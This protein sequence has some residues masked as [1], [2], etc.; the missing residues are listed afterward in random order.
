MNSLLSTVFQY[1]RSIT[2][3][4]KPLEISLDEFFEVVATGFLGQLNIRERI[5]RIR[6]SSSKKEVSKL[7]KQLPSFL[8]SATTKASTKSTDLVEHTGVFQVDLDRQDNPI[9]LKDFSS[10]EWIKQSLMEDEHMALVADSPSGTGIKILIH[11]PHAT[12]DNHSTIY[13]QIL[14]YLIEKYNLVGD[15]SCRN[16]N[17]M[18]FITWDPFVHIDESP[19]PFEGFKAQKSSEMVSLDDEVGGIDDPK[20]RSAVEL[21]EKRTFDI[22]KGYGNWLRLGFFF[23]S[24]GEKGRSYFHRISRFNPTYDPKITDKQFDACMHSNKGQIG[25]GSLFYLMK[26]NG[27]DTSLFTK[28]DAS[29]KNYSEGNVYEYLSETPTFPERVYELLPP[30]INGLLGMIDSPRA[31]DVSLLSVLTIFSVLM[32]RIQ[33]RYDSRDFFSNLFTLVVAPP[34]SDKGLMSTLKKLVKFIA[35]YEGKVDEETENEADT[36][37]AADA[38]NDLEEVEC[39]DT[40]VDYNLEVPVNVTYPALIK[41]IDSFPNGVLMHE[42]EIDV[43]NYMLSTDHGNYSAL[44]RKAFQHEDISF[45]RKKDDEYYNIYDPKLSVLLS[46]TPGQFRNLIKGVE[47]GLFS[48]FLYYIYADQSVF[49][50][51]F[52]TENDEKSSEIDKLSKEAFYIWKKWY[53]EENEGTVVFQLTKSQKTRMFHAFSEWERSSSDIHEGYGKAIIRRLGVSFFRLCMILSIIRSPEVREDVFCVDDDFEIA[54]LIIKTLMTHTTKAIG[55]LPEI[56]TVKVKDIDKNKFFDLLPSS[57]LP[58]EAISEG[59]KVGIV[60][61]TVQ[62]Y[63]SSWLKEGRVRKIDGRYVKIKRAENGK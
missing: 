52:G 56:E 12:L 63:Q 33:G 9:L 1:F 15:P 25:I 21:I 13:Q 23:S 11:A 17:R 60:K 57:W 47:N 42:T 7:K 4:S 14:D 49:R 61:R 43:M 2:E 62:R 30:R 6:S 54:L 34:A 39:G 38:E 29:E 44:L 40:K 22:T 10:K 18:M 37:K 24:Y 26:E 3:T 48:R 5:E 59:E 55:I 31:R 51:P 45:L 28:S 20:I 46:G 35:R 41:R 53:L 27:V 58:S 32:P 16:V 36:K 19:H 50:D 8:I